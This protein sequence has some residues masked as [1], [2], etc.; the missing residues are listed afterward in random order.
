MFVDDILITYSHHN[1]Q[2]VVRTLQNTVNAITDWAN[3]NGFNFS[4]KKIKTKK[5]YKGSET[6]YN[7]E[8]RM[9]NK[10]IP[11]AASVKFLGLAWDFKMSWG[12][13]INSLKSRC[14]KDLNLLKSLTS[15]TWGAH[16]E[17]LIRLYRTIIR[18]KI[19]YGCIVL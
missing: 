5:F 1:H 13:H 16:Q 11:V 4:T 14:L 9:G 19:V 3:Y 15:Y 18:P 7:P 2:E 6:A 10:R 17:T 12:Q 8:V